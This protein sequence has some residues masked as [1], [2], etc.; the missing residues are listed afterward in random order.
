MPDPGIAYFSY[1]RSYHTV[2]VVGFQQ[3]E[4]VLEHVFEGVVDRVEDNL[5]LSLLTLTEQQALHGHET[6]L[7]ADPEVVQLS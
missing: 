1:N 3:M 7:G 4:R 2:V 5:E 6:P